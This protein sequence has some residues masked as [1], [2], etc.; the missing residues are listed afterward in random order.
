[1]RPAHPTPDRRSPAR[2]CG[3]RRAGTRSGT[4]RG[5]RPGLGSSARRSRGSR[6]RT[7]QPAP[8]RRPGAPGWRPPARTSPRRTRSTPVASRPARRTS[9]GWSRGRRRRRRR[10]R[11]RAPRCPRGGATAR[12]RRRGQVGGERAEEVGGKAL[13]CEVEH[14]DRA[15]RAADAE[16]LAGHLP[17]VRSEDRTERRRHD[18]EPGVIEGQ[19]LGVGLDPLELHPARP[20]LAPARLE[21]LRREVR[22]DDGR[23]GLGRPNR[24]VARSR[25]DIEDALT[26]PDPTGPH[27][28][29]AEV[30]HQLR[31]EPVVVAE[32]PH[33]AR[34]GLER[35][36]GVRRGRD[37]CIVG[38][39]RS[40]VIA[41]HRSAGAPRPEPRVASTRGPA[42]CPGAILG[43]GRRRVQRCGTARRGRGGRAPSRR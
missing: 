4:R 1:M 10:A 36:V 40:P 18:V 9:R 30:P 19:G 7:P 14:P 20:G 6:G 29:R 2:A 5:R 38:T 35:P 31:R 17:M 42:L 13:G 37:G 43:P 33:C 26:G 23:P 28:D 39:H 32:C 15:A 11:G 25:S 22:C 34:R 3:R 27:E 16:E 12:A 8:G 24:H 41:V 21:V